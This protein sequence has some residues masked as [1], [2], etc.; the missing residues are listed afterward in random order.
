[1]NQFNLTFKPFGSS[2][3]LI[4]W[5][6]KIAPSILNDIKNFAHKIES[7]KV[8]SIKV[9]YILELNYIY[10]SMLVLYDNQQSNYVQLK[11]TLQ[12]IYE[13]ENKILKMSQLTWEVPVCY[14]DEF[15]LDLEYLS[16]ELSLTKTEIIELHS[17]VHYKV[18]G[19]GFLPGFLYLGGLSN[20]LHFPRK[21]TP[22]H[23]V[24][25]GAVGIGRNQTG[26]YPQTSPGGWQ[27][28]GETPINIFNINDENLCP[29]SPGDEI[30]FLPI[31]KAAYIK[32]KS[33]VL[34][35]NY[36]LKQK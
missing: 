26:I 12:H 7:I 21:I 30:S 1:M 32:I 16:Q 27:I 14:D 6:S 10:C 4:E 28:I 15:G 2:A 5:P 9:E 19:I 8:E 25:K 13:D 18:Y 24:P 33:E 29:I 11:E 23:A 17:N 36:C 22:R 35:G 31:S 20:K 3:I 34:N